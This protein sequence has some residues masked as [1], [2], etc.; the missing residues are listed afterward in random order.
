MVEEEM[1]T[2]LTLPLLLAEEVEATSEDRRFEILG[3]C[4]AALATLPHAVIQEG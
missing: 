4:M 3:G 1:N 2:R